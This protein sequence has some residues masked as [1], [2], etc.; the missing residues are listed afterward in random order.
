[1]WFPYG[2]TKREGW[3][4][5][6]LVEYKLDWG[7]PGIFG[8][9]ASGDDGNVKNGSERLP[10]SCVPTVT[11]PPSWVT[12][13]LAGAPT[14]TSWTSPQ[15]YAGTWGI[16]AQIR[17]VSFIDKLSHTFRVAYWG[18]TN[19]P[20]MVKYMDHA[21]AWDSTSNMFDGPYMTTNDGLLEFNVIST[22]KIYDNLEMNVELGYVANYM[23]SSTWNKSYQN[24]GSYS[25]RTPGRARWSSSTSSKH[26]AVPSSGFM[27]AGNPHTGCWCFFS[28]HFFNQG[29]S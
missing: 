16:G 4:A 8:W 15:S 24:F 17:D 13:T 2:S 29:F 6:A 25:S 10:S 26:P 22:Y 12:A 7:V 23:D 19:S 21:N 1:M 5:K 11:S 9:Y 27:P 28:S 18:G 20:S 14:L 3:L